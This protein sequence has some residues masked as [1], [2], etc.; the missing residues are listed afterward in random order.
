[1]VIWL[2]FSMVGSFSHGLINGRT[3]L[4]IL[5]SFWLLIFF[6]TFPGSQFVVLDEHITIDLSSFF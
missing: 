4:V 2:I 6:D 3:K 5:T 1:M